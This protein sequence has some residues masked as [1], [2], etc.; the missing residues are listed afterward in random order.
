MYALVLLAPKLKNLPVEE[1]AP[2]ISLWVIL[3]IVAAVILALGAV[4]LLLALKK[5]KP[6]EELCSNCGKVI[7]ADWPRCMFC[8]QARGSGKAAITFLSGPKQ[9]KTL[10]LDGPVTTIG[11]AP[12]S[13]VTLNDA[14]VSRKHAG[15]RKTDGGFELAD[16]GSTNGVYVNGEKV[17][18]RKLQLGD[19][20]R[21]GTTEMVFKN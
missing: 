14:G 18:K 21:V 8:K 12:G 11:T 3:V 13:T 2:T 17:A 19:V 16:L 9:G 7:M 20:I 4:I 5:Q 1:E 10:D 6:Q 15:I